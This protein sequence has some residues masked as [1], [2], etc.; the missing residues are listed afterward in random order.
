MRGRSKYLACS[1]EKSFTNRMLWF[2][3]YKDLNKCVV[4]NLMLLI[5]QSVFKF[6]VIN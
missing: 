4:E 2:K 1:V 3:G 6:A 5:L